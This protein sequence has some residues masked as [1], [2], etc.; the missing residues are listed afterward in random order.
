MTVT[1][2]IL[3]RKKKHRQLW[4]NVP[5]FMPHVCTGSFFSPRQ[6]RTKNFAA[7]KFMVLFRR[8][9][10]SN[11][12][13]SCVS[14]IQHTEKETQQNEAFQS[15][16]VRPSPQPPTTD[17]KL[18]Q[19]EFKRLDLHIFMFTTQIKTMS[20]TISVAR[21]LNT[22]RVSHAIKYEVRTRC[23]HGA[24]VLSVMKN[25]TRQGLQ[26]RHILNATQLFRLNT[27]FAPHLAP[28]STTPPHPTPSHPW[29]T[30]RSSSDPPAPSPSRLQFDVPPHLGRL[31]ELGSLPVRHVGGGAG[32]AGVLGELLPLQQLRPEPLQDVHLH[33]LHQAPG[34]DR[35][36]GVGRTWFLLHG[37]RVLRRRRTRLRCR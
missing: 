30:P 28:P 11:R 25:G 4:M 2:P 19:Q 12:N 18:C 32:G 17:Q 36:T 13:Y 6:K 3:D 33:R 24:R 31:C 29:R 23:R 5:A 22:C 9:Y 34:G 27:H 20:D 26:A 10:A 35:D 1:C 8:F 14:F 16:P 21:P 7:S 15:I 37:R